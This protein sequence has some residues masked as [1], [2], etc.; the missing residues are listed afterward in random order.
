MK[1]AR[2]AVQYVSHSGE[3]LV[4]LAASVRMIMSLEGGDRMIM[5]H[6]AADAEA[7]ITVYEK[8]HIEKFVPG[9]EAVYL[10][11]RPVWMG[12]GEATLWVIEI[13]QSRMRCLSDPKV[14][15][16]K[17]MPQS[18]GIKVQHTKKRQVL[19]GLVVV[20]A[21]KVS[22]ASVMRDFQAKGKRQSAMEGFVLGA[23]IFFVEATPEMLAT[24][25]L[26]HMLTPYFAVMTVEEWVANSTFAH[27]FPYDIWASGEPKDAMAPRLWSSMEWSAAIYRGTNK[28]QVGVDG[29]HNADAMELAIVAMAQQLGLL[30]K[31][32]VVKLSKKIF[33]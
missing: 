33:F 31:G 23:A 7:L 17:L 18:D 27:E 3:T 6:P 11:S 9:L 12:D 16:V 29:Q 22:I 32:S 25:I 24:N 28:L 15:F 2:D 1:Q 21:K 8:D 5:Y 10:T 30:T 14:K 26:K 4:Q 19:Q 13:R 20:Q